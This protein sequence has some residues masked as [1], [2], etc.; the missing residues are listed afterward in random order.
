MPEKMSTV[1]K[2]WHGLVRKSFCVLQ[3]LPLFS[4]E[5]LFCSWAVTGNSGFSQF[6]GDFHVFPGANPEFP[7]TVGSGGIFL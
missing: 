2:C 5:Y 4:R 7:V 6:I 1:Q 3:A